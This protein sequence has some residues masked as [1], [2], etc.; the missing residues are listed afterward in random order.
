MTTNANVN[1][2]TAKATGQSPR[3]DREGQ[4]AEDDDRPRS[5]KRETFR[6]MKLETWDHAG[7]VDQYCMYVYPISPT[8]WPNKCA[9]GGV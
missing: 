2:G 6:R 4:R 5:E 8:K 9:G 1:A 3:E 7:L